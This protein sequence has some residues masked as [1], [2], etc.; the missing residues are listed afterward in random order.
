MNRVLLR[1]ARIVLAV[2]WITLGSVSA[3]SAA[4]FVKPKDYNNEAT[5]RAI[6]EKYPG[7]GVVRILDETAVSVSSNGGVTVMR[8]ILDAV[9]DPEK[10]E[11]YTSVTVPYSSEMGWSLE[12]L[13][14]RTINEDGTI[15]EVKDSDRAVHALVDEDVLYSDAKEL[16]FSF[17]NVKPH[18]LVETLYTLT[19]HSRIWRWSCWFG[20][21]D[22]PTIRAQVEAK[23]P[24]KR[25][26]ENEA[27]WS[28]VCRAYSYDAEPTIPAAREVFEKGMT[29]LT[30]SMDSIPAIVAETYLPPA[31]LWL[32]RMTV[33]PAGNNATAGAFGAWFWKSL[34]AERIQPPDD[35]K[36]KALDLVSSCP[37][38][39]ARVDTLYK[40]VQKLRY[41]ALMLGKGGFQPHF[42]SEI[43]QAGYGD[44]KDKSALLISLLRSVGI[45]A[46]PVL[47]LPKSFGRVEKDIFAPA[48]F[49]HMIVLVKGKDATYWLDPTASFCLSDRLPSEEQGVN[50]MVIEENGGYILET[51]RYP[52]TGC[53]A[54]GRVAVAAV[55]ADS[56][57]LF[58]EE[59]SNFPVSMWKRDA[60]ARA[61]LVDVRRAFKDA[62]NTR[63]RDVLIDSLSLFEL[64][65]RDSVFAVC[66]KV[67]IPLK[68]GA[69]KFSVP[70]ERLMIPR[71]F[72]SFGAP[73]RKHGIWLHGLYSFEDTLEIRDPGARW[74]MEPTDEAVV[75]GLPGVF[76]MKVFRSGEMLCLARKFT[77]KRTEFEAGEYA[78]VRSF[79]DNVRL[80][81]RRYRLVS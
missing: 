33:N 29:K 18:S 30:W 50:A 77:L 61:S 7:I 2:V 63:N 59:R 76:Q 37:D 56:I 78:P 72:P 70:L 64:E 34:L 28:A 51:P 24:G 73:E 52:Q 58:V 11:E 38:E 57:K 17:P 79:F 54:S 48:Q 80:H 55:Q 44:C 81:T 42:V 46:Y 62:W 6:D 53:P 60:Y 15:L 41:V 5:W 31:E 21:P 69:G 68:T 43:D 10:A 8:H 9:A 47:V 39:A 36:K 27:D 66:Y 40:H 16:S 22:V 67:G 14:A 4:D 1:I 65:R 49:N 26:S 13:R 32:P 20:Y 74:K 12:G 35:L 19:T 45:P 71:S 75:E 23:F 25:G 3:L